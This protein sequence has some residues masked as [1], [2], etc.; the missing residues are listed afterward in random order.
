MS[1]ETADADW[2]ARAI[3]LAMKGRGSVEPNPL[4]G[5]VIVKNGRVIGEGFHER[6]GGPHAEP[7]AMAA[8][9]AA[10]ESPTGATAY[11]T[12]E[13]CCHTNKKTPPCVPQ[14]IA[15][16]LDRVV[17]G[18]LDPNPAV[19]G[20][21]AVQLRSAGIEVTAPVLEDEARQL[22]AP[23]LARVRLK[24][25]YV[26]LKWAE[27]ADGKVAGPG[28][29]PVRIS[30]EASTQAV[31]ELRGRCDAIM[32]GIGT[33]LADDPLL[34]A[35]GVPAPRVLRRIVLDSRL[36]IP[37]QSWLVQTAREKSLIVYNSGDA[38][39]NWEHFN[40]LS[41]FGVEVYAVPADSAGRPSIEFIIHHLDLGVTHLLVEPGPELARSFFREGTNG[42]SVPSEPRNSSW[43]GR[44]ACASEPKTQAGRLCHELVDRLWV[45]RSPMRIDDATAPAAP[46]VPDHFLKTAEL[47]LNGDRLTEYLNPAS[48]AFIKNVASADLRLLSDR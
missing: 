8:C 46:H 33:V 35:R 29:N 34:T 25:P 12:L 5:C 1:K 17:I 9:T 36:R 20:Q 30:N 28:G 44:P 13:P 31:H 48:E 37:L 7:N 11:V 45:F 18:C 24:R 6:F 38:R 40:V 21:G 3:N 14:L 41:K 26:T 47:D 2:M 39:V 19:N 15:A 43:H 27:S 16:S 22:I 32:V 4:V 42:E 23:F 10:G